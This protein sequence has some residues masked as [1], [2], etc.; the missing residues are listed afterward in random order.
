MALAY[1]S[2]NFT[3]L[4]TISF[5]IVIQY[6][7]ITLYQIKKMQLYQW[8]NHRSNNK[9]LVVIDADFLIL[10]LFHQ[11]RML[12]THTISVRDQ[13]ITTKTAFIN[14]N[15]LNRCRVKEVG[16]WG[17]AI[18]MPKMSDLFNCSEAAEWRQGRTLLEL[19]AYA[20]CK[21]SFSIGH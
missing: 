4:H 11:F 7:L 16:N 10:I 21:S 8:M 5:L 15:N 19:L 18:A 3:K 9:L 13:K 6:S 17:H 1:R 14:I 2:I 20:D 12:R